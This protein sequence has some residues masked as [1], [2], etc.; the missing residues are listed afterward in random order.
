MFD[1]NI[2]AIKVVVGIR[3]L[4]DFVACNVSLVFSFNLTLILEG[5]VER[6]VLKLNLKSSDKISF[7]RLTSRKFSY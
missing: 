2:L 3:I 4:A 5:S 6:S 7:V 1:L